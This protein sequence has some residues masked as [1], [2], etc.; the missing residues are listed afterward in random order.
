MTLETIKFLSVIGSFSLL[1]LSEQLFPYFVSR[2]HHLRHSLRNVALGLFNV[3]ISLMI[4]LTLIKGAEHWA[5]IRQFGLLHQLELSTSAGIIIALIIIDLWQYLWHRMNHRIPAL[6]RF[7]RV[8]HCDTEMDTSS[9]VRF[10]TGEILISG[11]T[12]APLILV[13]GLSIEH[14]IIYEIVAL[15]VILFHHSN[16]RIPTSLDRVL[17]YIIMTPHMHR[18]HHSDQQQETDSNYSSLFSIWDRLF[19]S[20]QSQ[21]LREDFKLGLGSAYSDSDCNSLGGLLALPFSEKDRTRH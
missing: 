6:W 15:P 1:Y 12:R 2:K 18:L 9:A 21:P 3:T 7:H 16:L 20:F 8:H 13:F 5:D 11:L 14:L 17:R 19:Y 10:H 4:V